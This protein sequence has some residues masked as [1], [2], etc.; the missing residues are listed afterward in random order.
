MGLSGRKQKQRIG[1][2]PRNLGWADDAAR[3][4]QN[5]LSK[6]G[7][8][9]SKGLGAEGD[10]R[11]SH[12]KV[13]QKLD[14]LGIGA[15][16]QRDPNGIAW[17]QNKDFEN[18]LRRLN[19]NGAD[20]GSSQEKKPGV[21][22]EGGFVTAAQDE[23][24]KEDR[25]TEKKEKKRKRKE[26]DGEVAAS[27]AVSDTK[28][29]KRKSRGSDDIYNDTSGQT[30][31][32]V[33]TVVEEVKKVTRVAVVPRHRAHRARHIASKHIS[34]KS[35]SAIAEILGVASTPA[36]PTNA[37]PQ[38]TLTPIN[39]DGVEPLEKL[40]T[41]TKSVS[42][43]FKERLLAKSRSGTVTPASAPIPS[44]S[45]VQSNEAWDA[46]PRGGL[47]SSK[48]RMEITEESVSETQTR[49][50]GMS[51]FSSLTSSSFLA[52]SSFTPASSSNLPCDKPSPR[53]PLRSSDEDEDGDTRSDDDEP[54]PPLQDKTRRKKSKSSND[55]AVPEDKS[56]DPAR[57]DKK[58]KKNKAVDEG[59][60]DE[61]D[62]PKKSKKRSQNDGANPRSTS[63]AETS[64]IADEAVEAKSKKERKREKAEKKRRKQQSQPES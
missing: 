62:T 44:T 16:Q 28:S 7:W 12:L 49:G 1:H 31:S 36:T 56:G 19:E 14:M 50:I 35:A 27:E 24:A 11:I 4:G 53:E 22:E 5:Y 32:A 33:L 64:Q 41:S 37:T 15:A 2:D 57:K 6:F 59:D 43:Y 55:S 30:S 3:F 48:L 51:M 9:P 42:D 10:G 17:K 38:G 54:S 25:T 20:S 46:T 23:P 18:L 45:D 63:P 39:D 26:K 34:S 29:K 47:G 21:V 40:M 13:S 58:R 61:A 60:V 52:A 8:D